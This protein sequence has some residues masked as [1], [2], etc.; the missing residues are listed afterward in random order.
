MNPEL[1]LVQDEQRNGE[2]KAVLSYT[3]GSRTV[4]LLSQRHK[5]VRQKENANSQGRL[6]KTQKG[7]P[8]KHNKFNC[9]NIKNFHSLINM[10]RKNKNI[11]YKTH[12]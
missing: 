8:C 12:G 11:S 5:R 10:I 6:L 3:A 1:G 9:I 7:L 4:G 2:F